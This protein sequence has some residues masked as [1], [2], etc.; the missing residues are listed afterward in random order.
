MN[1]MTMTTRQVQGILL[2]LAIVVSAGIY[3]AATTKHF[4]PDL[5]EAQLTYETKKIQLKRENLRRCDTLRFYGMLGLLGAVNISL[6]ILAAGY[7]RAKL[8]SS[9]V[10]TAGSAAHYTV[11]KRKW[12]Q[13]VRGL[14]SFA[15]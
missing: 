11:G 10:H 9:S 4:D 15:S 6:L 13:P 2:L 8:K 3:N 7:A 5:Q 12:Q 14:A 1:R